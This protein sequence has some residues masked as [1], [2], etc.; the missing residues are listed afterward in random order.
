[1]KPGLSPFLKLKSYEDTALKGTQQPA[2]F[3]FLI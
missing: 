1:M 2:S 3:A